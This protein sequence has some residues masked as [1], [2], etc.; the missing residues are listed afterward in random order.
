MTPEEMNQ[1]IDEA[2]EY[3]LERRIA[4][5]LHLGGVPREKAVT[6]FINESYPVI[7]ELDGIASGL[8]PLTPRLEELARQLVQPQSVWL[9]YHDTPADRHVLA[10]KRTEAEVKEAVEDYIRVE[11]KWYFDGLEWRY[12]HE[13]DDCWQTD[14][15]TISELTL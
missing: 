1:L 5:L 4:A 14:T 7:C 6:Y 10:I 12:E 13:V 15:I 11:E 3:P 8:R 2:W 9:A